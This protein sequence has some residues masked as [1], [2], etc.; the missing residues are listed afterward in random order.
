M[1]VV[2]FPSMA[3]KLDDLPN[4]IRY[5]RKQRNLTLEQLGDAVGLKK[6]QIS[7][8]ETGGRDILL[9]W[10]QR[11]AQAMDLNA[12]DLLNEEDN[13]LAFD[14]HLAALIENYR[15]ASD[16]GRAAI[17]SVAETTA[18]FKHGDVVVPFKKH[19]A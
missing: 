3:Q 6:Q 10:L 2:K 1:S 9:P 16:E 11:M 7:R 5:W 14:A 4:R 19:S 12:A 15:S 13:P 18:K 8:F 17:L